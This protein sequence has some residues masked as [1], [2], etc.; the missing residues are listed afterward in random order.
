MM[1]LLG[2]LASCAELD[3]T[4]DTRGTLEAE[5]DDAIAV[6]ASGTWSRSLGCP[7]PDPSTCRH[8]GRFWIDLA[9]RN[10]AYDKRV[11]VVWI[12]TLR[13]DPA[14][15]WHV[16]PASYEAA[17][18]APFERWGVDATSHVYGDLEPA[19]RIRFAAFVEMAGETHWDNAGGADHTIP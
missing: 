17:L 8:E 13:D 12:D 15:P 14:G 19:P 6:I 18:G 5:A 1:L 9:I 3:A 11:G 16:A 2:C 4:S 10:D 7:S